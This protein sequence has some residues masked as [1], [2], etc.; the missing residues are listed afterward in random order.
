M[1]G[2][3]VGVLIFILFLLNTTGIFDIMLCTQ[4]KSFLFQKS[5]TFE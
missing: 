3:S 1:F 4:Q 5:V 2:I